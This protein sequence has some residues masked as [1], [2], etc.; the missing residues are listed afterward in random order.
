[1]CSIAAHPLAAPGAGLGMR[2]LL[3]VAGVSRDE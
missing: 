1:V 2:T 3:P